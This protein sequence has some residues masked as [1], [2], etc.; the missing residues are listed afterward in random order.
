LEANVGIGSLKAAIGDEIGDGL[1][2][3]KQELRD[4]FVQ[5]CEEVRV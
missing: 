4:G 5:I 1:V 2:A 3:E